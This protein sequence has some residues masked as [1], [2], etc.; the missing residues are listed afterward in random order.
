MVAKVDRD[1]GATTGREN[2]N[3]EE[4][5]APSFALAPARGQE[6]NG[7]LGAMAKLYL[8][9]VNGASLLT[10]RAAMEM[11]LIAVMLT[12]NFL[13][14]LAVWTAPKAWKEFRVSGWKK[15]RLKFLR[16]FQL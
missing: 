3:P 1:T 10:T 4:R 2:V 16:S 11:K 15:N 6:L 7:L 8:L 13:F 9:N 5:R 14:D 12:I